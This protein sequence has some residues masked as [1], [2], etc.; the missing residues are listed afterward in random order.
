M[1]ISRVSRAQPGD[2]PCLPYMGSC[3]PPSSLA[4]CRSLCCHVRLTTCPH[5]PPTPPAVTLFDGV[6]GLRR[7]CTHALASQVTS[8]HACAPLINILVCVCVRVCACAC[9]CVC[10]CVLECVYVRTCAC[11]CTCP[12]VP[13]FV[14]VCV[15]HPCLCACVCARA[16]S[17]KV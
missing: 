17:G 10:V 13:V 8:A 4:F 15:C 3:L 16:P 2:R 7:S 12:S 9:V 1:S 6:N 5:I 14:C 11:A